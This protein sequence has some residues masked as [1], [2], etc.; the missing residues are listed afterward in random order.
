MTDLND[1]EREAL[2]RI[3]AWASHYKDEARSQQRGTMKLIY[4]ESKAALAVREE[5]D[6]YEVDDPSTG[7]PIPY[8]VSREEPP[9]HFE[10]QEIEREDT[11]RERGLR[12]IRIWL[13]TRGRGVSDA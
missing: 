4:D 1:Q 6:R 12:G 11:E 10:S 9:T 5:P 7:E 3:C 8:P 13:L 2:K